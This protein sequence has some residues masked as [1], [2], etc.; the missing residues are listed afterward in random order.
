MDT[1]QTIGQGCLS[2]VGC[3]SDISRNHH[4][5]H[6]LK[7]KKML[8]KLRNS[9]TGERGGK[10]NPNQKSEGP[11]VLLSYR[12]P[13]QGGSF[14]EPRAAASPLFP[15]FHSLL[16]WKDEF[17]AW[18]GEVQ[19]GFRH[20]MMDDGKFQP[21]LKPRPKPGVLIFSAL[22]VTHGNQEGS[23]L[24]NERWAASPCRTALCSTVLVSIL[25]I[26]NDHGPLLRTALLSLHCLTTS[27]S[28]ALTEEHGIY[29]A[30]R[31][32][33]SR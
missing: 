26:P 5:I 13:E 21:Q 20:C 25:G 27:V 14:P 7:K 19:G 15:S 18:L 17:R 12:K 31:L 4:S 32:A 11:R 8:D 6:I 2:G 3:I 22:L 1:R 9:A 33:V 16:S 24:Y 29:F 28:A 30:T 10:T 23:D